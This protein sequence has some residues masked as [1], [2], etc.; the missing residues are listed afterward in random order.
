ME[1]NIH[2]WNHQP[3][4]QLNQRIGVVVQF[5]MVSYKSTSKVSRNIPPDS[6]YFPSMPPHNPHGSARMGNSS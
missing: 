6:R 4:I 5:N 1:N 2:A 3:D